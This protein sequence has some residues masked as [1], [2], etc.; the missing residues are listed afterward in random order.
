MYMTKRRTQ[1]YLDEAQRRALEEQAERTGKSMGQL[2]REAVDLVYLKG[3]GRERPLGPDDPI[4]QWVGSGQSGS[5][6]TSARHD[7]YLYGASPGSED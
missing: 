5:E 2:I 1:L 6:D 7:T 4:W 3:P